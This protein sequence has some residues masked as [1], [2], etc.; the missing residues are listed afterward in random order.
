MKRSQNL[1][2]GVESKWY[3]IKLGLKLVINQN[4]DLD[5]DKDI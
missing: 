1:D 2:L 4:R 3:G 5:F